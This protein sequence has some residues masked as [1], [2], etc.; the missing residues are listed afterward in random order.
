MA[1]HS[2]LRVWLTSMPEDQMLERFGAFL[3]TVTFSG[4]RPGFTHLTIRAV[5]TTETPVIELDLRSVPLDAAGIVEIAG[6]QLHADASYEVA[7]AWDLS[8]FDAASGKSAVE[9]QLLQVL[10]R[11]EEFDREFWR[12]NGHFE[13][14]L[15]FEHLFTGHAGLLAGE[16]G[17][18]AAAESPEQTRF[19]EAMAWPENLIIYREKTQENIRKLMDWVQRIEKAVPVARV[20]LWSESDE[21]LEARLDEILAIN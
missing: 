10:C 9:P 4:T 5:D 19:L 6:E 14:N 20:R 12:E 17:E 21:N 13:V 16:N 15:G 3:A 2:Y 18:N 7:C 1:N 11:G 8:V